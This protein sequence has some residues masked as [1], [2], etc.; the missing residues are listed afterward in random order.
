MIDSG[1]ASALKQHVGDYQPRVLKKSKTGV[2]SGL[3]TPKKH[4]KKSSKATKQGY[5]DCFI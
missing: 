5:F 2:V 1:V 3:N 4:S